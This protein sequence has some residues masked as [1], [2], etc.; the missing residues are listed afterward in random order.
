[1]TID[2]NFLI[3]KIKFCGKIT[4]NA[5][6]SDQ[7]IAFEIKEDGSK[8]TQIDKEISDYLEK[9]LF[10]KYPN[11]KF[12]S[13]ENK[14]NLVNLPN[15]KNFFLADPIDGTSSFIKKK[16]EFT[17][18]LSYI[19]DEKMVFSC[20]FSPIKNVLYYSDKKN[21][22]KIFDDKTFKLKNNNNNFLD[23]HRVIATRRPEELR[24]VNHTL[25]KNKI[26]YKLNYASSAIK[27]CILA[28]GDADIYIRRAN[29]KLWDVLA[30][31]HI[32]KNANFFIRD[33]TG[34][35]ILNYLLKEEYLKKIQKREFRICEFLIQ[36]TDKVKFIF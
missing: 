15:E 9:E 34:N 30:G 20:I 25:K 35:N 12:F 2:Q 7:N 6:F 24:K 31:F 29:I 32:V 21:S 11:I 33:N 10:K 28:D 1:M 18:N 8:V 3:E 5:F 26:K 16:K 17:I 23:F 4:K 36:K 14:K 27:F 22:Y 13:E 19:S